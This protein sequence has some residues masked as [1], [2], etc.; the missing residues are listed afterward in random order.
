MVAIPTR[1]FWAVGIREWLTSPSLSFLSDVP[2]ATGKPCKCLSRRGE[3]RAVSIGEARREIRAR[4]RDVRGQRAAADGVESKAAKIYAG[5]GREEDLRRGGR[6][7][8]DKLGER[9]R[10]AKSVTA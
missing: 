4:R 7:S 8:R 9:D 2:L 5:I 1:D 6:S 10:H 3:T